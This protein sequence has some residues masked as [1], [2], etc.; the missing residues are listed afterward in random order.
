MDQTGDGRRLKLLPVVDEFTREYLAIEVERHLT[1]RDVVATLKYLFELRGAGVHPLG[2]R[3]GVHRPGGEGVAG[4]QRLSD[5]VH[6]AGQPV[7]ERVRRV[8]QR[9]AGGRTPGP[10]AVRDAEGGEG[11][12]GGLPAGVQPPPSPQLTELPDARG[13]RGVA[14]EEGEEG[15]P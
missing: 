3:A 7:G 8:V 10:G 14:H 13:V 2:Q 12:G 11:P 4:D 9:N 5:A 1:A 6:R 15:M